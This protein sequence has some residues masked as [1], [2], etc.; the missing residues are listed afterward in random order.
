MKKIF[1]ALLFSFALYSC[2]DGDITVTSFDL[3]DSD[4]SL[5]E[6]DGKKVLWVVNNEDVYESMSLELN[7]NRL[8][9]TLTQRILTLAVNDEPIEINLS[10][11]GNR[12]V[13]RIYDG[14]ITGREYFCQG[15]PPG[16]PRVLEEYVSAGGTVTITTSFNDLRLD[17]NA[18]ADGDKV[19]NA[20][21]G[22]D[23][24]GGNHLDTDGDGIPDYLDKDDDNDNVPTRSE[25]TA[26]P[27]EPTTEEGF[28]NTDGEDNLPDYLDPDDDNDGVLTRHEVRQSEV[29]AGNI[30]PRSLTIAED[31]IPNFRKKEL[32]EIS[33]EHENQLDHSITRDYRSNIVIRNFNL[34][35]QDG[36]GE[37][38]RFDSYNLG[39]LVVNNIPFKLLT[40]RQQELLDAEEEN[41]EETEETTTN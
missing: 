5:C 11:E 12:L 39:R 41:E 6:I 33:F 2:D 3:E 40:N 4:L 22:F 38:I 36:S 30:D 17:E 15:V 34:I 21:E 29:E 25:I 26:N 16:S 9:D 28:L 24:D 8:N 19:P 37:D 35:R 32:S 31:G 13:Y 20:E 27:G 14:E 18:D 23:P 1:A 7:D 10:G